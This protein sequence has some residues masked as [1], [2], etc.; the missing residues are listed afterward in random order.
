M[1][2]RNN[3]RRQKEMEEMQE[4][5]NQMEMDMQFISVSFAPPRVWV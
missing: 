4:R 3:E 2:K 5:Y 1:Y